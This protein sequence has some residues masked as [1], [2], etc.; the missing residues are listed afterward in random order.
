M[1]DQAKADLFISNLGNSIE[2]MDKSIFTSAQQPDFSLPDHSP[3]GGIFFKKLGFSITFCPPDF[4]HCDVKLAG[5]SAI[6]TNVQIYSGDEAYDHA[7]YPHALPHGIA[8]TDNRDALLAKLG[9]AKW[10]FPF[11]TPIKLERWDFADHWL[12]VEYAADGEG[13]RMIQIGLQPKPP[14]ASVL[15]KILQ[16][17]IA[18]LQ[19]LF[20]LP[21]QQVALQPSLLAADFSD[22]KAA[23][24]GDEEFH[25]VDELKTLGLELYF[26][27]TAKAGESGHILTG[28]RYIRKGV[29]FSVGFDGELPKGLQFSDR[30]EDLV[31]KVG[32]YPV[33]GKADVLTGYF[34]WKLPEYMLHVGFSVMEQRV[35]RI[36][37]AAHPYYSK[38]LLESPKLA[39][40]VSKV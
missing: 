22:L 4:Y 40:P 33:T 30:P 20:E 35:N 16:P 36:R 26:R 37:V 27:P 9:P 19:Q 38:E 12:N 14:V 21:W 31:R 1:L 6:L 32:S 8:F 11:V 3:I 23:P 2:S 34:V 15:P 25:E 39:A 18:T 13:L 10:S 17:N 24:A 7:R 5:Q 28:A 29:Y